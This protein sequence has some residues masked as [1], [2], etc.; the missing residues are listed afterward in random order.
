MFVFKCQAARSY[1]S[2]E[3]VKN[4]LLFVCLCFFFTS[5]YSQDYYRVVNG[6]PHLPVF[7]STSLVTSPVPGMFIYSNEDS[8]PKFFNGTRWVDLCNARSIN[9]ESTD[10]FKIESGIPILPIKS[11]SSGS[12]PSG[13]I[14]FSTTQNAMMIT[15]QT[16]THRKIKDMK[17]GTFPNN[18]SFSSYGGS[19]KA[20]RFPVLSSDPSFTGLSV[21][22]IYI[23]STKKELRCF[24]GTAW[25]PVSCGFECGGDL[26]INHITGELAPETK[27]VNYETTVSTLSGTTKCWITQNLGASQPASSATDA[28]DAAAGWYWQFDRVQ[29]FLPSGTN[30]VTPTIA[31]QT[32]IYESNNWLPENDPCTANLGEGWRIPFLTEWNAAQT[33]GGMSWCQDYY[34]SGLKL[35]AAGFITTNKYFVFRGVVGG[36]WT[37]TSKSYNDGNVFYFS[38]GSSSL[39]YEKPYA[40]SL[41]CIKDLSSTVKTLSASSI[42][43]NSASC[44][45]SIEGDASVNA[46]KLSGRG[47][48]YSVSPNPTYERVKSSVL[49]TNVLNGTFTANLTNLNPG[50]TYYARAYLHFAS[51]EIIYGNEI[52]FKTKGTA[53]ACGSSFTVTHTAGS[54]IPVTKTVTYKTVYTNL[55]GEYKCWLGQN[56][57]A[58]RQ[59]TSQNEST[60]APAGWYW[61]HGGSRGIQYTTT[62]TPSLSYA[63]SGNYL[64][65]WEPVK[66]PCF[67]VLGDGWRLPTNSEWINVVANGAWTGIFSPW[68]SVLKIHHAGYISPHS[69]SVLTGRGSISALWS[70]DKINT[71][72]S[73]AFYNEKYKVSKSSYE[74]DQSNA[75]PVRCIKD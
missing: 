69:S 72:Y 9:Q 75:L 5:S 14:Y 19:Y 22:A 54:T 20:A 30:D 42:S 24:D 11:I 64:K 17:A 40:F 55:S 68:S 41:R 60:E 71:S 58:D 49:L 56:L 2:M 18:N 61:A 16:N 6:I 10:Y 27:T 28:S 44:S 65:I 50:T 33:N 25:K 35:H 47:I 31:W 13:I 66:D 37:S 38:C 53:F 36:F 12:F 59:A 39:N 26:T 63:A 23:S 32:R 7:S 43:S 51:G 34:D 70:S 74:M 67:L 8:N 62:P 46:N 52:N 4:I 45:F 29:G 1:N 73:P 21:G 3:L 57:G 15:G 48:C